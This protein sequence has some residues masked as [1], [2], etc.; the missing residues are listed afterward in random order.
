VTERFRL[1]T[2]GVCELALLVDDLGRAEAF[3]CGVLGL[4]VVERW[5]S[6]VWVMAGSGTRIGLWRADVAPLAGEMGGSHVHY[7]MH[8]DDADFDEAVEH[9]RS[10]GHPV[11]VENFT[12]GRGRA[13]YVTDPDGNVLEFW[14]WDVAEHLKEL[15][16]LG[17]R[18]PSGQK[19]VWDGSE[20]TG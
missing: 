3:Y 16:E 13:S 9:L 10:A 18:I 4:P 8:V 7:A 15:H 12:D 11:H 5:D 20:P 19:I 17:V 2:T 1:K 14:T 6:A